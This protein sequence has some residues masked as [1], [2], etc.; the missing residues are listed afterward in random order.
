MLLFKG[1]GTFCTHVFLNHFFSCK[2]DLS[3][4]TTPSPELFANDIPGYVNFVGTLFAPFSN[5]FSFL[6]KKVL[7]AKSDIKNVKLFANFFLY[8][9][10]K[11]VKN[12]GYFDVRL[13]IFSRLLNPINLYL[14][15]NAEEIVALKG[16]TVAVTVVENFF[17][18]H[19]R[20]IKLFKDL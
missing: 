16:V 9:E 10:S 19:L 7:F 13:S 4:G 6:K 14:K 15:I 5:I 3:P 12:H 20:H 1:G 18:I 8:K 11:R 2:N 17:R